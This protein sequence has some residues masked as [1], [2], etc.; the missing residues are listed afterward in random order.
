MTDLPPTQLRL[1]PD[2]RVLALDLGGVLLS[3]GTKTAFDI[4]SERAG[5]SADLLSSLWQGQLRVPAELGAVPAAEVYRRF[6]SAT[7][8]SAAE[9]AELLIEGFQPIPEGIAALEAAHKSGAAVILATNHLNEWLEIWSARYG[10][11]ALLDSIVC[12]AAVHERKPNASFYREVV[13]AAGGRLGFIFV[14]DDP[15]NVAAA[16]RSGLRGILA[17]PG[18]SARLTES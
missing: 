1:S 2:D 11:W 8:L 9:V 16:T 14:D 7:G 6:A 5:C 17:T 18:W 12:S 15:A 13:A 10:W 4:M 3:D